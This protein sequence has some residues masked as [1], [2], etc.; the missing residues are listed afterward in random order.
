MLSLVNQL[1]LAL[2]FFTVFLVA[3]SA[4]GQSDFRPGYLITSQVD[5]LQGQIDLRSEL[6]M[7]QSCKFREDDKG[8]VREYTPEEILAYRFVDNK[9][10]ISKKL[11]SVTVFLEYIAN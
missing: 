10:F 2:I 7:G 1:N 9:Y 4:M 8:L 3:S 6:E 11:D 5:T